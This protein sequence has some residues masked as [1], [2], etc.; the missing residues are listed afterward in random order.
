MRRL[1]RASSN[2]LRRICADLGVAPDRALYVGDSLVRGIGVGQHPLGFANDFFDGLVYEPQY[3]GAQ[4]QL[5]ARDQLGEDR[6]VGLVHF[7]QER[8]LV[9]AGVF[10]PAVRLEVMAHALLAATDAQGQAVLLLGP[11]RG[12]PELLEGGAHHVDDVLPP[13]HLVG[14]DVA[15]S[16]GDAG[17]GLFGQSVLP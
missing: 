10:R 13:E 8:V 3:A 2:G 7:E 12:Q 4:R 14:Q 9:F 15:H 17:R 5:A 1:L 11:V 16:G 6:G